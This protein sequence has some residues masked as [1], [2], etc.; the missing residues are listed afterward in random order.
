[1]KAARAES[2]ASCRGWARGTVAACA[3]VGLAPAACINS[4]IPERPII[5]AAALGP[6]DVP[7]VATPDASHANDDNDDNDAMTLDATDASAVDTG[8]PLPPGGVNAVLRGAGCGKALPP[9][10][11]TTIPGSP[12]GYTRYTVMLTGETL[13]GNDPARSGQ[14][15]F[16][17]RVPADYNPNRAYRV[18]YL[19]QPCG[20]AYAANTST[21]PLFQER[22]GGTEQAIYVAL[23]IPVNQ[24][25][26]DCYDTHAG[27]GSQEWEAFQL[28][29]DFVDGHYCVDNNRVFVAGHSTGGWLANMWGCYFAG[30]GEAPAS[31]PAAPRKF[32]PK[33]HIRAEGAVTSGE[34]D[35]NP[36]CN[37]PVAA[38]WIHDLEDAG[39]PIAGAY[40]ACDRAL[41]MNGCVNTARCD[42]PNAKTTPWHHEIAGLE[43]CNQYSGCPA[44]Y[45]VVFCKSDGFGH[46]DQGQRAVTAF[47]VFFNL[48]NPAP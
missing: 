20:A 29:Q 11:V 27:A 31:N 15:T 30:D 21:Y 38:L 8:A 4:A 37:G 28:F 33:Y 35:N 39:N 32:A 5:D 25:T 44:D 40:L 36:L 41:R 1:M 2:A 13:E 18:V 24:I 12:T 46:S 48:L 22:L 34:P 16:W 43:I 14:R 9:Q 47:G 42:D 17:V 6:A 3:L 26:M 45:P 23:D 10:T 19:G 7:V